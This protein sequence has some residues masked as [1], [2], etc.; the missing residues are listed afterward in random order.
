MPL[1]QHIWELTLFCVILVSPLPLCLVSTQL[2]A[3]QTLVSGLAHS[4]LLILM[5]WCVIQVCVGLILGLLHH[6]FFTEVLI[7]E[8]LLFLSGILCLQI[9]TTRT[10]LDYSFCWC[11]RFKV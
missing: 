9:I 3:T 6:L 2:I 4:T 11:D 7:V 8:T 5:L 1:V 10:A